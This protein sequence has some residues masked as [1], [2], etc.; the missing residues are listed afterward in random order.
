MQNTMKKMTLFLALLV[1]LVS[2]TKE[3]IQREAPLTKAK[4]SYFSRVQFFKDGRTPGTDTIWTL[5]LFNQQMV[6]SFSKYNG[7]VYWESTIAKEVGVLW[8]K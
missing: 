1:L 3:Q 8:S 2:C 6:D 7:R 5:Q 4:I